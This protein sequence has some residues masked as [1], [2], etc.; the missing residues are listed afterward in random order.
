MMG[1][2]T[3]REVAAA[4]GVT[5][6][7]LRQFLGAIDWLPPESEVRSGRYSERSFARI[8]NLWHRAGGGDRG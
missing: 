3:E 8:E 7:A 2:Y 1:M 4:L 6:G 5:T